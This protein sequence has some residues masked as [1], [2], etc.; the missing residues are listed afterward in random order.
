MGRMLAALFTS[1]I[2]HASLRQ[3]IARRGCYLTF[4]PAL[5]ILIGFP[6]FVL[7]Y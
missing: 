1:G 6:H 2:R 7:V 5:A 3:G 4:F